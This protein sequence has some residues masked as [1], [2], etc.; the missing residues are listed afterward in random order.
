[1]QKHVLFVAHGMGIFA[2]SEKPQGDWAKP[3]VARLKEHWASYAGDKVAF[4]D[5]IT[6]VP[7]TYDNI[8]HDYWKSLTRDAAGWD[9]LLADTELAS[10]PKALNGF[11]DEDANFVLTSICDVL[12]YRTAPAIRDHIH[13]NVQEQIVSAVREHWDGKGKRDTDFSVLAHSLGTAVMHDSMD[14]LS[15]GKGSQKGLSMGGKSKFKLNGWVSLAN[16]SR[17]LYGG[18][19]KFY[20]DTNVQPGRYVDRFVNVHHV[21]DPFVYPGRFNPKWPKEYRNVAVDHLY[22]VNTHGY[23]HY[24][25]NPLVAGYVFRA[26]FGENMVSEASVIEKGK[27]FRKTG[28]D[29]E[30]IAELITEIRGSLTNLFTKD[31]VGVPKALYRAAKALAKHSGQFKDLEL[32]A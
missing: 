16:V 12:L 13:V 22:N 24:L 6:V 21:V 3:V 10:I 30:K 7:I 32:R 29:A 15:N 2:S 8:F 23:E 20:T 19:P 27:K 31:D 4:D 18:D 28:A 17:V 1:M 9:K 26:M 11:D 25:Q 5:A 14:R